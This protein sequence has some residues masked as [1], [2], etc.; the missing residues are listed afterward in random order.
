VQ[1]E[2]FKEG[3]KSPVAILCCKAKPLKSQLSIFNG[4]FAIVVDHML[5][6]S[7]PW[8]NSIGC[9]VLNSAEESKILASLNRIGARRKAD[10][11]DVCLH[12]KL[13]QAASETVQQCM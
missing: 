5:K 12:F 7:A 8:K 3:S 10:S 1:P 13:A 4:T 11:C 2:P 6:I 9:G